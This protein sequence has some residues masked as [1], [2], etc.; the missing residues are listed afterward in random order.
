MH[1]NHKNRAHVTTL[2]TQSQECV[3]QSARSTTVFRYALCLNHTSHHGLNVLNSLSIKCTSLF[4]YLDWHFQEGQESFLLRTSLLT[5]FYTDAAPW[6]MTGLWSQMLVQYLHGA[7]I[8][9]EKEV[10][11]CWMKHTKDARHFLKFESTSSF[12]VSPAKVCMSVL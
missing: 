8:W 10:F 5:I 6:H 2:A 7:C 9:R 3:G 11:L 4:S 12:C 1:R